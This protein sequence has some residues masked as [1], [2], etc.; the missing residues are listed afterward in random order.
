MLRFERGSFSDLTP[1]FVFLQANASLNTTTSSTVGVFGPTDPNN[2]VLYVV[3]VAVY[4][5]DILLFIYPLVARTLPLVGG[6][7]S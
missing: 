4:S 2:L 5:D 7:G 6:A 1:R 3:N